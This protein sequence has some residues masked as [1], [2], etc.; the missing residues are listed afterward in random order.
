MTEWQENKNVINEF[1]WWNSRNSVRWQIFSIICLFVFSIQQVCR[2]WN[3]L[4][5]SKSWMRLFAFHIVLISLGKVSIWP[6]SLLLWVNTRTDWFLW[7]DVV[8]LFS[9]SSKLCWIHLWKKVRPPLGKKYEFNN[10]HSSY[11]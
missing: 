11:G 10:S 1:Y 5:K 2:Q 9:W 3:Q 6:I 8:G 4:L 7:F